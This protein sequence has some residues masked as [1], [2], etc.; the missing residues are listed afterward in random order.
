MKRMINLG[1]IG[2][3]R[4]STKHFEAINLF[5]NDI[6]LVAICE[7]DKNKVLRLREKYKIPVYNNL[8]KMIKNHNLDLLVVCTPSGFHPK[9]SIIAFK[10]KI[11]VLTE[12]PMATKLK[13]AIQMNKIAKLNKVKLFVVKQNRFNPTLQIL[14]KAIDQNRFGKIFLIIVNVLWN[15]DQKY[16]DSAKWRGS[17]K[18]DGGALMNQSSHYVDLLTWLIGPVDKVY[19][20]NRTLA[21]K[22][23]VEDTALVNIEFKSGALCSFSSTML[24]Y[25][26]NYEGSILIIGENGTVKIG[27]KAVNEI[28]KWEFKDKKNY[29]KKIFDLS[30]KIDSVY[31]KGHALVYKEI[32]NYF[33]N[34]KT[35]ETDGKEGMKSLEIIEASYLS[36]KKNK[37]IKLPLKL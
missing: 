15:R 37:V 35:F 9:H 17:R 27:G 23:E 1:L 30:Y 6:N 26:G 31:G 10:N 5:T 16:Y 22:I 19:S 32:I 18:Y 20:M 7:N 13:D 12:K 25:N 4:I 3:G 36:S 33:N 24:T 21:R 2:C 28:S 29:D 14:K 34:N 8:N 11:N